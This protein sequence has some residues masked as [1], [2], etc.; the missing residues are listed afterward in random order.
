MIADSHK[1][2]NANSRR[3]SDMAHLAAPPETPT[4]SETSQSPD[5]IGPLSHD[6][7]QDRR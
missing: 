4:E 6:P 2:Q 1:R 3:Q 5:S 7:V